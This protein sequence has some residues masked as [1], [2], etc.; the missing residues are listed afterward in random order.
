MTSLLG[1]RRAFI[2]GAA[3]GIGAAT[4]RRFCEEGARA[5]LADIDGE[6]AQRAARELADAGHAAEALELDV[7]DPVAVAATID[8]A[9][10]A[11]GGLD[12]VVANAGVFDLTPIERLERERLERVVA[13]NLMGTF[14]TFKAAIV[15]LRADGGGTLL[16]TASQA[17][18]RGWPQMSA[19]SASKFGVIGLVQSLAQELAGE[20]IRVCAVAPGITETLMY[21]EVI[22]GRSEI[23]GVG[24]R[25]AVARLHAGIP[26]GRPATPEEVANAH[27]YLASDM[28]SYVSGVALPLDGGELTR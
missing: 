11:L 18:L 7:T 3:R 12:L 25:E 1:G 9:A 23:W 27:V 15:H 28:A 13:V 19:Y 8:C 26:A 22:D 16:A 17:G 5:V 24:E 10:D 20:G 2:T 14:W 21:R 6:G 4:A